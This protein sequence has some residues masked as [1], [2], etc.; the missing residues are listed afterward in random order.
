MI[1][2]KLVFLLLI[3][4]VIKSAV[5][6]QVKTDTIY[7]ASWN[8]ENL[9]DT[10][11]DPE[12]RDEEFT[13]EGRKEW[14]K[15][16]LE[17][18]LENIS[19]VISFMN[20]GKGP[21]ILGVQEVEHQHLLDTLLSRYFKERNYA[22]AYAES[23]DGRG[24][25]NA[26]IYDN[27]IFD[28][29]GIE[30][31][32][33]DL[34]DSRKTRFIFHAELLIGSERL[35]VFVNHWPSRAGGQAES[36]PSRILAAKTLRSKIDQLVDEK[37]RSNI[38]ILGDFNDDP[39][40]ISIS[41]T[42]S[43]INY[44]CNK[45]KEENTNL[46]NLSTHIFQKGEGSYLYRGNWNMLDQIIISGAAFAKPGLSYVCNSFEIIKPKFSVT[47]SGKFRG[48]SIPTYGGSRYLGGFSDH[49]SVGAKFVIERK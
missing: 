3:F 5:F 30:K 11:D 36:E 25:D 6:A 42:L 16:K 47:K 28:L 40:N 12:K 24:I 14:T 31:I 7:V 39:N 37:E 13:P 34:K 32:E 15:E 49:F 45:I 46:Y 26:L 35:H 41:E 29:A 2:F 33:V 10:V 4:F 1:K 27:D 43:A 22:I 21:D 44:D 9:F 18:K 23:P 17:V 8:L 38:I 20:S 48:S 19:K